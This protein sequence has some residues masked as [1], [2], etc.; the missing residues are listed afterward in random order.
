MKRRLMLFNVSVVVAG[1]AAAFLLALPLVRSLVYE[2]FT[3]RLDTA[4]ALMAS[5]P[6]AIIDNPQ[7]FALLESQT[8]EQSGQ[9]MRVSIIDLNGNVLGDSAVDGSEEGEDPFD[10]NHLDRPE[11]QQAL[12]EGHGYHSRYS[13]SV[14]ETFLYA[15]AY[16]PDYFFVRVAL[17]ITELDD[18][19]NKI[20]LFLLASTIL[21]TAV[22]CLIA[23]ANSRRIT[24]PLTALTSAAV[25]IAGGDLGS[26]AAVNG[27]HELGELAKAFNQM[28]DTTQK[29]IEELHRKH[30]QL[31]GV[32]QGMDDGV[33]AVSK[34][35]L[36]LLNDR[37]RELLEEPDLTEGSPLGGNLLQNQLL[38]LIRSAKRQGGPIRDTILCPG[39]QERI[40]NVYAAPLNADES[41]EGILAVISDITEMRRLQQLRSEF[42]ANVT[43]E[44]KTPL[45][46]IRGFIELLKSGDR[47]EETR[48]YFYDVLDIE[49]ERLH[50]LID[51][52]LVLSQIENAKEDA[53][54]VPCNVEESLQSTIERLRPMAEK[55]QVILELSSEHDIYVQSSPTRLQQMFGNLIENAIKYNKQ[56]GRVT[57]TAQRQRG[58]AVIRVADT[59]IGIPPE[60]LE[61]LFER[62][63]RV[64]TSRSREIGGTGLGLSIVK[65]LAGLYNGDVSVEST[66]DIGSVFT[67]RLPLA[68]N[69]K[70]AS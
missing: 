56:N 48:R 44:L 52:M 61:R 20:L 10:S 60:H 23:L 38:D 18:V 14:G 40:L 34:G 69:N 1:L 29:T 5:G 59:G 58:M 62:F 32:L 24:R 21:G 46:S 30:R 37:A 22:A 53:S 36:L 55:N 31:Q 16:V 25:K 2:E 50:H 65:H 63:Y 43:H 17:P 68:T 49:A 54:A 9:Q 66:P 70:P 33:L 6:Q 35:R 4:L 67:V 28:A 45:T 13:Q 26:R 27:K 8:L 64:D 19:M 47:D 39:S 15:A 12:R 7:A 57:V 51:D 41:G 3:R 42:V 11:I